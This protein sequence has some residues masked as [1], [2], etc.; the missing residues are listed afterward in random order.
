MPF[1]R[2][3]SPCLPALAVA[4]EDLAG[5]FCLTPVLERSCIAVR[6]PVSD[7]EA[8]ASVSW[9]N[10]D[11]DVAFPYILIASGANDVPP[12][13]SDGVVVGQSVSGME[14]DWSTLELAEP[15]GSDT[16][17]LYVIFQ[18]PPFI[19]GTEEGV[20]PGLGY[21]E[22]AER[23][24][25]FVSADGD[26]WDRLVTRYK[27]LV[28]TTTVPRD[29]SMLALKCSLN[30][31]QDPQIPEEIEHTE[32]FL[33]YPNPFNP[34]TTIE[35]ALKDAASVDLSVYD[36]RGRRVTQLRQGYFASGRYVTQWPGTDENGRRSA[37]G[38]YFVRLMVD[39]SSMIH[40]VLLVK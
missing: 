40:R 7:Q 21:L 20:G 30:N 3:W 13:Y 11:G 6:V 36:I 14:G 5:Y 26:D 28:E 38:V 19:E 34:M 25:V 29:E 1:S 31:G 37:S 9:Y 23:S 24:C 33:P 15:V 27:L 35:F 39:N 12:L 16:G 22:S 4:T 17:T 8:I 2:F 32:L 18:L 10:N